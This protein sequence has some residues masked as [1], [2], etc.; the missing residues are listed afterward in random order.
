[1]APQV[2]LNATHESALQ[3]VRLEDLRQY[4]ATD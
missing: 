1:M 4:A 3:I 2:D